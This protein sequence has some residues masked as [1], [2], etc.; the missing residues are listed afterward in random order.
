M[1]KTLQYPQELLLK[2]VNLIQQNKIMRISPNLF[3]VRGTH[4][5]PLGYYT[6]EKLESGVWICNCDCFKKRKVTICSH[7]IAVWP[8]NP[9]KTLRTAK[10]MFK[11]AVKE[12]AGLG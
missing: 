5:S 10:G 11:K 9:A 7:V 8:Y 12:S 3:I 2:A 1:K 4:H 6:V